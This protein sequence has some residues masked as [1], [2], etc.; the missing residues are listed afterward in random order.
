MMREQQKEKDQENLSKNGVLQIKISDL[1][2]GQQISMGGFSTIHKGIYHG[3]DVV[4]KKVFNPNVNEE[5][6]AD[7]NT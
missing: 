1:V 3:L 7:F 2:I 4:V 5:V 6:M